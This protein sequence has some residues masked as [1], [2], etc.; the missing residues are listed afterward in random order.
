MFYNFEH[1]SL[2]VLIYN[3]YS[4]YEILK[5]AIFIRFHSDENL[6][7]RWPTLALTRGHLIKNGVNGPMAPSRWKTDIMLVF[8]AEIHEMLVRKA[9]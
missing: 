3:Q 5:G 4:I 1:F 8:S 6:T 9:N 2:S 7:E